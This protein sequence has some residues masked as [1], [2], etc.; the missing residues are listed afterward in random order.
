MHQSS[1][2]SSRTTASVSS[3]TSTT[4]TGPENSR[5]T[6]T[7]STVANSKWVIN[8]SKKPLTDAQEKLLAYGPNFAITPR[9]SPIGEYIAAVE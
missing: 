6:T 9:N 8:M 2:D 5:S 3:A 1:T 7:T 4:I